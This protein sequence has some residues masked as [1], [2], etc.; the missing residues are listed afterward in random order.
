MSYQVKIGTAGAQSKYTDCVLSVWCKKMD[1]VKSF[2]LT[3]RQCSFA[4]PVKDTMLV[5]VELQQHII[6]NR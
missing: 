1:S 2:L 3:V 5:K 6:R 4:L